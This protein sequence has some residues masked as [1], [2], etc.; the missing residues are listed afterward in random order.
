VCSG[1]FLPTFR[2][3]LS[4]PSSG[5]KNEKNKL[6]ITST[7]EGSSHLLRGGS[8]DSRI[9]KFLFGTK[10]KI[11]K[12]ASHPEQKHFPQKVQKSFYWQAV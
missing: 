12:Q 5:A 8:L 3:N 4:V 9:Q 1:N 6:E 7:E 11:P 10:A 2:T